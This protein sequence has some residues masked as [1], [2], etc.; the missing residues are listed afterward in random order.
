MTQTLETGTR[1]NLTPTWMRSHP[2]SRRP[3]E[4]YLVR[5]THAGGRSRPGKPTRNRVDYYL[6]RE[7]DGAIMGW[8]PKTALRVVREVT[9]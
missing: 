1:V 5:N 6:T 2:S 3:D 9:R 8:Y 7:S 4:V